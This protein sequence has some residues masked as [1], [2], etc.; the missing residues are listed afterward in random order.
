MD[1]LATT[2]T[3]YVSRVGDF[4]L[5]AGRPFGLPRVVE[6]EGMH[7][8]VGDGGL[9]GA[10]RSLWAEPQAYE[11]LLRVRGRHGVNR[12]YYAA[13]SRAVDALVRELEAGPASGGR[14]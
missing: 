9:P 6:G 4:G 2:M 13:A 1:A 7:L 8:V 11:A 3:R 14:S 12:R 5:P 10:R